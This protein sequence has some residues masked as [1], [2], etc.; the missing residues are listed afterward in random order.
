V[1]AE[2]AQE[3]LA[4]RRLREAAGDYRQPHGIP[5]EH[6]QSSRFIAVPLVEFG[7]VS[8]LFD[9]TVQSIQAGVEDYRS[10]DA[11]RAASAVRN[12]YAGVL[13]LAKEVL[14]RAAP[15]AD[16]MDVVGARYKP[17]PDQSGGVKFISAS[18]NTI[19]FETIGKRFKDFGLPIDKQALDDLNRIRAEVEH[20]YTEEPDK[21]VREAIAKAFPVVVSLFRLAEENPFEVL[22]DAWQIMLEVRAVYESELDACRRTFESVEWPVANATG[23]PFSCPQCHS[24]LVAQ[25]DPENTSHENVECHCRA[26]GA[27]IPAEKAMELALAAH[28]EWESYVAFDDGGDQP[29]QVCPSCGVA[30]YL[31]T[32]EE[33]GCVWCGCALDRCARCMTDLTPENVSPS[34]STLC[35]YCDYMMSKD[36]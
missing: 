27:R 30:A 18:H 17:V 13:L 34:K 23:T 3:T 33:P 14:A 20:F 11:K 32:H 1:T 5:Y 22:G 19:D 2:E 26:C 15:N 35:D 10:H 21:A 28:F 25:D 24:D 16:P 6:E 29:V 31:V 12:F 36:D 7:S 4:A 9:N 8:S